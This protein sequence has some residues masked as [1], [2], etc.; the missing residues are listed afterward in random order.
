[1][2]EQISVT[3][4]GA[5][6]KAAPNTLISD[7]L[8]M[9]KPCGGHAKC[10]KC[11]VFVSG[12]LSEPGE[13]EKRI[14]TKSELAAGIRLACCTHAVGDCTVIT[15]VTNG[16]ER[17][18]TD[19]EIT[20]GELHPRFEKY[21]ISVDVGT[22]TVAARLFD[23][24]GKLRAEACA[25]NPQQAHG[26]DVI[27]RIEAALG[28]HSQDL[29]RLI[30]SKLDE[31]TLRLA[32]KAGI[33][34]EDIDGLVITGNSVMLSLLT[35]ESVLSF[36][37]AP[38]KILRPFGETL[39][40]SELG[41]S[42]LLPTTRVYLPP[43]ISAFVGADISC[44]IL[45]AALT[46]KSC[47]MLA[48]IGTNGEIALSSD[49]RL[50]VCST[51]AGPAFEGVGIGHGMRAADG[52][53]DKVAA[54]NGKLEAHVIGNCEA[55]GICGSGLIDAA[56]ALIEL[57]ILD[58]SGYLEGGKATLADAVTL[59]QN[60][61]R[62]LQL[63]KSAVCAGIVTLINE[64]GID[65][66][67][68][69]TLYVAGGFGNYLSSESAAK[70]GLL[71]SDLARRI[72]AVGNAAL[73]GA[74]MLLLDRTLTEKIEKIAKVAETVELHGNPIFTESYTYGMIF[75]EVDNV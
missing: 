60:D 35:E 6:L 75:C 34:T 3:V 21:G 15:S 67:D 51:A 29:A 31:L 61:I 49:G 38:F 7:I 52:A 55:V 1:M 46:D 72:S 22:T 71:P 74:S 68:V 16:V 70:T 54:V 32:D 24:S 8:R 50:L 33:S 14:L 58:E 57:G 47:A 10:G 28:G 69:S 59:T 66:S 19:S 56:A 5:V 40:A 53:I 30:R 63:A 27:S 18:V 44:A 12:N 11:K 64:A 9:E 36:S 25:I 43:C 20:P 39:A 37:R 13:S 2:S 26:A 42:S 48:D 17:I 45:A 62:M 23:S 73:A 4:N 65:I 41:L